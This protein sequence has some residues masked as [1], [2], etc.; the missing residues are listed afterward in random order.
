MGCQR[1]E[2]FKFLIR[3][4]SSLLNLTTGL[5]NSFQHGVA[6]EG[7]LWVP[8]SGVQICN[9]SAAWVPCTVLKIHHSC[10]VLRFWTAHES[11]AALYSQIWTPQHEAHRKSSPAATPSWKLVPLP[12]SKSELLLRMRDLG[13]SYCWQCTFC[14]CR[15]RNKF[16]MNF[17]NRI[18]L[19]YMPFTNKTITIL[20]IIHQVKVK[21]K[22]TLR[23]TYES[24]RQ[25]PIWDP[26]PN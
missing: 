13:S 11:R 26:R 17:W 2:L 23:P 12:C 3:Y 22:V 24:W 18:I 8:S 6:A 14:Q 4:S 10:V 5:R 15:V 21:V 20:D 9:C 1:W 25:A 19:L 16:F 7:F